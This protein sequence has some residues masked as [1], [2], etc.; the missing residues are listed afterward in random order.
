VKAGIATESL[1]QLDS[2]RERVQSFSQL[3]PLITKALFAQK[4]TR[5]LMVVLQALRLVVPNDGDE[6]RAVGV[7]GLVPGILPL[8]GPHDYPTYGQLQG[9]FVCR[10]S[11]QES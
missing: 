3:T 4:H 6:T 5:A 10:T 8:I 9:E 11:N 7:K 1:R 2:E